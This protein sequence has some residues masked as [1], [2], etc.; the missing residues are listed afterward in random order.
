MFKVE[1]NLAITLKDIAVRAG[2]H[3]STVSRV[4]RGKETQQVS[5]QTRKLILSIAEELNYTPNQ[6]ARAFRLK[7]T[8]TIALLIPDISNPFFAGLARSIEIQSYKSGYTLV[9]CNTDEDQVK[10]NQ[11]LNNLR[12]RGIDGFIIA[13]VQDSKQQI[14]ELLNN[15]IPFVLID[16]RF[17]DLETN[18]VISDNEESSFNAVEYLSRY[19]HKSIGFI[20]GRK[21]LYTIKK[22]LVG[23]QN[24]VKEFQLNDNPELIAGDGFTMENGYRAAQKLLDLENP[25]TAVISSGN[26][27]TIGIMKAIYKRGL[28][29]PRDISLVGFTDSFCVPYWGPPLTTISHPLQRM[30]HEA[31]SLL[32]KHLETKETLAPRQITIKTQFNERR[33][34]DQP[35]V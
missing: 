23:F 2:V 33:S 16:R 9:V 6:L 18:A 8:H 34:V 13:P 1:A 35:K 12:S 5:P 10:E 21:K 14:I 3:V 32:L 7:K 20:C 15:K 29:I 17:D 27:I 19:H 4:L 26:I 11:Y 24:A 28:S 25:P 22:R 31:F 30:G